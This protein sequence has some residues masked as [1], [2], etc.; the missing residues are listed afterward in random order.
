M[1]MENG[2]D[3]TGDNF[4]AHGMRCEC[5]H[6]DVVEEVWLDMWGTGVSQCCH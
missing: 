5:F 3:G 6:V 2:R 1:C 4:S